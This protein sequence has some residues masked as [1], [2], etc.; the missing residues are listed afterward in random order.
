ML[1]FV[2]TLLFTVVG[3]LVVFFGLTVLICLIKLM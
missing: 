2:D 1:S 3:M